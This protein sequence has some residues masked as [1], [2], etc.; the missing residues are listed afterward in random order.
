MNRRVIEH[1]QY[2][3]VAAHCSG[4]VTRRLCSNMDKVRNAFL[5]I[6]VGA[7]Q[8]QKSPLTEL[9]DS[10][11]DQAV[12]QMIGQTVEDEDRFGI[13]SVSIPD[14]AEVKLISL[15]H[16]SE[17]D[18]DARDR[19]RTDWKRIAMIQ[20]AKLR[21]VMD[22]PHGFARLCAV[23]DRY[24]E[25]PPEWA[26]KSAIVGRLVQAIQKTPSINDPANRDRSPDDPYRA[27]LRTD[28]MEVLAKLAPG[29]H[30]VPAKSALGKQ[31]PTTLDDGVASIIQKRTRA[32]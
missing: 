17:A 15:G 11:L 27:V 22:N 24:E 9:A 25:R 6:I 7:L 12:S 23:M 26:S 19:D 1:P 20:D 10:V 29:I 31:A 30:E 3:V 32:G 13:A 28:L 5:E 8:A 21:A 4:M 14:V 2:L 16:V 18:F